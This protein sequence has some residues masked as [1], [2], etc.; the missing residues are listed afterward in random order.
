MFKKRVHCI[1]VSLVA[2]TLVLILF[3]GG[4]ADAQ[5][6][7]SI[8][9]SPRIT[10]ETID[11]ATGMAKRSFCTGTNAID[12]K[13]SN[14]SGYGQ[15]VSIINRDTRGVERTLF[16]GQLQTGTSYLSRLLGT[17]LA[18]TGPAGIET[19]QVAINGSTDTSSQISYYV[20]ECGSSNPGGSWPDYGYPGYAQVW[21]QVVPYAIE[22]GKKGMIYLQASVGAQSY[23]TYYFEILNS[24]G[25]LWKRIP[26]TKQP[27]ERYLVT[28][29]VGTKTKPGRLTYTVNILMEPVFGGQSQKIGS[30]RFSFMVVTPGSGQAPYHPGYPGYPAPYQDYQGYSG[31]M[32]YGIDPY[33][34]M[35]TSGYGMPQSSMPSPYGSSSYYGFSLMGGATGERQIQ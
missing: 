24:W 3:S 32:P 5:S 29:P 17:Q 16:S 14:G 27:Y 35:G 30:S 18:L 10:I 15:Y 31:V 25:Q 9:P 34:G 4:H 28:L 6:T 33:A 21:A 1:M 7:R 22:Q 11:P 20:Q 8:V 23:A 13:I 19:L 2:L 26:I 12:V